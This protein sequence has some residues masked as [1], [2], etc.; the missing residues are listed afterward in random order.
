MIGVN[1]MRI[2]KNG[3]ELSKLAVKGRLEIIDRLH[4]VL[5]NNK[6]AFTRGHNT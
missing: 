5:R 2:N 1:A 4:G 6:E 3:E